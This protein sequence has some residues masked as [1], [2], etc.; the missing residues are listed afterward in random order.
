LPNAI[1]PVNCFARGP[2]RL[3]GLGAVDPP[4]PDALGPAVVHDLDR[5]AIGDGYHLAREIGGAGDGDG[6]GG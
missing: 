5:V 6:N 4:Q 2:E 1:S 3:P